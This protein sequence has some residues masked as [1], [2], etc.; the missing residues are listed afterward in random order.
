MALKK[1]AQPINELSGPV[2]FNSFTSTGVW[3]QGGYSSAQSSKNTPNS[4]PGLLEVFAT[5]GVTYQRFTT[6][7]GGGVYARDY[8]AY[9]DTW[10]NWQKLT[11]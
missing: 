6:Y 10:S 9:A 7:R 1:I 4:L 3:H 8:Y 5:N 11:N 2:D